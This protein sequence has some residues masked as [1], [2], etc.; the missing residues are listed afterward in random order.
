MG[1]ALVPVHD[2][3]AVQLGR[4]RSSDR[5]TGRNSTKYLRAA[6]IV[7][8]GLD[9]ED[10]LEMDFT[11]G[12]RERYLLRNGD[13]VLAE[14]S[15][16]AAKVGRSALWSDEIEE[17]CYQNTVIRFR[18]HA[19][20]PEYALLVF[21]HLA[22]SGVFA[23]AARGLGIQHLGGA[24]ILSFEVSPAARGRAGP[25]SGRSSG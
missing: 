8:T 7:E 11:P 23:D 22:D 21:R 12:E 6:N 13:V 20:E 17:C 1:G 25:H 14:A 2:V 4:Q 18:P 10:V 3:G 9:L 19:T 24:A 5:L 16:S 15:G